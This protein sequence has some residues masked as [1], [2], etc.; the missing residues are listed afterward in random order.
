MPLWRYL[1]GGGKRAYPVWHRRSGKDDVAL[2]WTA[3][4]ALQKPATYWHMLP[5]ASQ[6]RKAIWE[7]VN[8]HTGVRRIDQA[9]PAEIRA[10]TREN[11]MFIRLINGATWQVVGSDNFNSL[12]GSPP[13]GIVFSEWA[14]S[15]PSAW[16][17]LSPILRENGGWALFITTPRGENH[18]G[19][20]YQGVKTDPEW[21]A[22]RL[23]AT[24]TGVFTPEQLAQERLELV[25]IHG[26]HIGNSIFEQ[27]Y[28]CSF[29]SVV[30]GQVYA[31]ELR[32]ARAEERITRVPYD[33]SQPV[34]TFWDLGFADSTSI[35]FVQ[36]VGMQIRVLDFI[37]GSQQK[38]PFYLKQLSE[39]PYNY[40]IH[41]LPHDGANEG[42]GFDKTIEAQIRTGRP[43]DMVRIVPKLP[44]TDGINALR[45]MFP[46]LWFDAE[47]C[48]EGLEA[49]KNYHYDVK[50]A[51]LSNK[52][53]HDW[54]SHAADAARYMAI[55]LK[56]PAP[57]LVYDCAPPVQQFHHGRSQGLGWMR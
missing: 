54:S 32:E 29:E 39:K 52:P 3:V 48:R 45:T 23:D 55:A 37:Q 13:Y 57:A 4:S 41:W 27:E 18:A 10:A 46:G 36:M 22:Q 33:H 16:S 53:V 28:M 19:R 47:K 43:G 12:V 44:L 17:F 1:E 9:F 30:A 38:I 6:A 50:D 20:M 7:A 2:N 26:E 11:E 5:E 49:L 34:H 24:Q 51:Q 25:R 31:A 40:G 21:F 35:W 15:A 56:Q 8:P 42:V 14:L